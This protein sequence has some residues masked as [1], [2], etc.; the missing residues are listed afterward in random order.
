M[1]RSYLPLVLSALVA[2]HAVAY[3][4]PLGSH[5]IR[6]AYFIGAG[7]YVE[8]LAGYTK[9][10]L[11]PKTGPHVAEMEVRTPFAQVVLMSSEH[12]GYSAQRAAQDYRKN[13]DILAIA[14]YRFHAGRPRGLRR[15]RSYGFA[16]H[17]NACA[18]V[19]DDRQRRRT[20]VFTV[21]LTLGSCRK[22]RFRLQRREFVRTSW[23][24]SKFRKIRQRLLEQVTISQS[25]L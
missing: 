17:S 22:H 18:V 4:H 16:Q 19:A 6:E 24:C 7:N 14:H 2:T 20:T 13:P 12:V 11:V 23:I 3:D 10:L 25:V 8:G 5:A 1:I 15:I 9:S 21:C